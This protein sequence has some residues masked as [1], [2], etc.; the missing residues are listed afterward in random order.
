MSIATIQ[1][2]ISDGDALTVVDTAGFDGEV[3]DV[4]HDPADGSSVIAGRTTLELVASA[5]AAG[6][7]RMQQA[8]PD[9]NVSVLP[10]VPGPNEWWHQIHDP[11]PSQ[12]FAPPDETQG[13]LPASEAPPE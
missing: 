9:N 10:G 3:V 4:L 12:P 5:Y 6:K 13:S 8:V 2:I 1:R 11:S 7:H